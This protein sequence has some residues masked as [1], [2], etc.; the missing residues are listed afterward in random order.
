MLEN[1]FILVALFFVAGLRHYYI[2]MFKKQSEFF[3]MLFS[4]EVP[5]ILAVSIVFGELN[6]EKIF[7][8]FLLSTMIYFL[9][10]VFFDLITSITSNKKREAR[11]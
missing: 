7:L 8:F 6:F 9:F 3:S 11:P 2:Q 1:I 4:L 10:G 5:I